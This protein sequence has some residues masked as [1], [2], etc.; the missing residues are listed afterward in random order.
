MH[1]NLNAIADGITYGIIA[2][3]SVQRSLQRLKR[4]VI[5]SKL[6]KDSGRVVIRLF[7]YFIGFSD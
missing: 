3:R 7:F 4:T 5:A 2:V 1:L 6:R